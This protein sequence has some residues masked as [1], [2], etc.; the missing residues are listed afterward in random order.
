MIVLSDLWGLWCDGGSM[1]GPK[2]AHV[3]DHNYTVKIVGLNVK[4][5]L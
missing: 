3:S 2:L 4:H 1:M 5:K